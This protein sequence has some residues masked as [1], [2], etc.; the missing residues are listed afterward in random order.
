MEKGRGKQR[1]QNDVV[2]YDPVLFEASENDSAHSGA[3]QLPSG[4]A[5]AFAIG[6]SADTASPGQ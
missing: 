2:V 5:G 4:A 6:V 1:T 3:F